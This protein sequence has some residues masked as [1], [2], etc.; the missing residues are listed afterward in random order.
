MGFQECFWKAE[1]LVWFGTVISVFPKTRQE[2]LKA[3]TKRTEAGKAREQV[4][5]HLTSGK[6]RLL[7]NN[8]HPSLGQQQGMDFLGGEAIPSQVLCGGAWQ[9]LLLPLFCTTEKKAV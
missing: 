3:T 9:F 1:L 5:L 2:K 7:T 8:P 6:Q 4:L